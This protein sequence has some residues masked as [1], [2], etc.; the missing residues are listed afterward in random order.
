MLWCYTEGVIT[1]KVSVRLGDVYVKVVHFVFLVVE[2]GGVVGVGA[3]GLV[4]CCCILRLSRESMVRG[5]L[6]L[7]AMCVIS[8]HSLSCCSLHSGNVYNLW[9]RHR[10]AANLCSSGWLESKLMVVSVEVGLWKMPMLRWV[11]FLVMEKNQPTS[12]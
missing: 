5:I 6:L 4:L 2:V 8:C 12:T 7:C 9:I 1:V 3:L 10:Y 11:G